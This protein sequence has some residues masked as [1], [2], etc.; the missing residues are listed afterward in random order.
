MVQVMTTAQFEIHYRQYL[1]ANGKLLP[2]VN[3]AALPSFAR[4]PAELLKMYK[5]MVLVRIFDT[6]AVNLQRTGKLGTYPPALGHEAAQVGAAAALRAED[7]IA[8]VYRE[9]GTQMW[10]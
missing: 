7:V 8:P 5:M 6:K 3:H 10:R 9:I 2:D 1:D 4:D